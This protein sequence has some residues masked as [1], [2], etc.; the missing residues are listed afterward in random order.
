[1]Q[2]VFGCAT[3]LQRLFSFF[4]CIYSCHLTTWAISL[5]LT[6]LSILRIFPIPMSD[7]RR[8][9]RVEFVLR[10][11]SREKGLFVCRAVTTPFAQDK[12]S[13]NY[14]HRRIRWKTSGIWSFPSQK[15]ISTKFEKRVFWSRHCRFPP[16]PRFYNLL[17]Y[18][19]PHSTPFP[20]FPTSYLLTPL[21]LFLFIYPKGKGMM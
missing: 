6:T 18:P 7:V 8:Y 4:H 10:R 9:N 17:T 2:G 15:Q 20:L 13:P 21:S 11:R 19:S 5:Q 16:P 14:L 1:M 12:K 3:D